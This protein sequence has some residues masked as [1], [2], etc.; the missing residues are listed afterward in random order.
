MPCLGEADWGY[1]Q[2]WLVDRD[3]V[4]FWLKG[5]F[6]GLCRHP[7][8]MGRTFFQGPWPGCNILKTAFVKTVCH[9]IKIWLFSKLSENWSPGH[10][11]LTVPEP[12]KSSI[13]APLPSARSCERRTCRHRETEAQRVRHILCPTARQDVL[14]L[15]REPRTPESRGSSAL[16]DTQTGFHWFYSHCN[17]DSV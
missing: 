17:S 12:C 15:S 8:N 10:R 13:P 9:T 1:V 11:A 6:P 7:E 4:N 2:L 3:Q 14:G 16:S 5:L